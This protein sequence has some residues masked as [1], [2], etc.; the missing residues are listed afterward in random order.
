[1]SKAAIVVL[2]DTDTYE[3]L[4]RIANAL[5]AVKEFRDAGDEV[6]LIFDGAGVKWIGELAKP[7]HMY[8]ELYQE[9]RDRISG[10]CEYCAEAFKVRDTIVEQQLHLANENEG[11]PSFRRLLQDGYQPITF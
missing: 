5:Y 1:M 4:G 11:H 8:H 3:A 2:A 6:Q 7:N 9:V 10:V